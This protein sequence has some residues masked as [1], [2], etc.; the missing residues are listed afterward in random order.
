MCLKPPAK[1]GGMSDSHLG[2]LASRELQMNRICSTEFT[3]FAV[4][5]ANI[6]NIGNSWPWRGGLCHFLGGLNTKKRGPHNAEKNMP[7]RDLPNLPAIHSWL[8]TCDSQ[9]AMTLL[10]ATYW[11]RWAEAKQITTLNIWWCS[12]LSKRHWKP[13]ACTTCEFLEIIHGMFIQNLS[14]SNCKYRQ[15]SHTKSSHLQYLVKVHPSL[16][17]SIT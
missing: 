1:P 7:R 9:R 15:Q 6:G 11:K 13:P 12:H 3:S 8:M 2:L 14:G 5:S 17:I 10:E 4:F 16:S